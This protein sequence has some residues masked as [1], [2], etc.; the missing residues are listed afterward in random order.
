MQGSRVPGRGRRDTPAA[1]GQSLVEIVLLLSA[2]A[3]VRSGPRRA[4]F[5][6]A[7]VCPTDDAA[8]VAT[9]AEVRETFAQ[10]APNLAEKS[11]SLR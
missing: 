10:S 5:I 2:R 6:E 1:D 3:A 8:G 4:T 7:R 9:A 11:A